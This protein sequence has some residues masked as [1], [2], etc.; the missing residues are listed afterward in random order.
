MT[1]IVLD[2][3]LRSKLHDLSKPLE[4]CDETGK[5]LALLEPV[6]NPADYEPWE[7]PVEE[8]EL[9]RREQSANWHTTQ[10]VLAHLKKQERP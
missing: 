10:E 9:L 6:L 1:R 3:A 7:P 4:L 5:V 2:A 8:A